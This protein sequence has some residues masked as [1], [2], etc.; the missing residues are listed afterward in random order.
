MLKKIFRLEKKKSKDVLPQASE[1]S[2]EMVEGTEGADSA[3]L[4]AQGTLGTTNQT[5]GKER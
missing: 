5:K 3:S 4:S 2:V 1:L